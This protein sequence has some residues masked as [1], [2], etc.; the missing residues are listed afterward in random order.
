MWIKRLPVPEPVRR[1]TW[2][3]EWNGIRLVRCFF[4]RRR[5][6]VCQDD[7]GGGG[8]FLAVVGGPVRPTGGRW[9]GSVLGFLK[10]FFIQSV[11]VGVQRSAYDFGLWCAGALAL[12][13][14]PFHLPLF[15]I[16]SDALQWIL[17]C[18]KIQQV[19]Y[20]DSINPFPGF[21]NLNFG[22]HY[23]QAKISL[24]LACD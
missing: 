6:C 4:N 24:F 1:L 20:S 22:G 18:V 15:K 13:C 10:F 17:L 9:A 11:E 3:T 21:V 19:L 12:V 8:P 7:S 14:Q 23:A 2:L 5:R 16:G